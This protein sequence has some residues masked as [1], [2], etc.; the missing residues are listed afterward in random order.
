MTHKHITLKHEVKR[1]EQ[2]RA[3]HQR[4]LDQHTHSNRK[5]SVSGGA[6]ASRLRKDKRIRKGNKE[7]TKMV[8]PCHTFVPSA[9]SSSS[10]ISVLN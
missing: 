7:V 9:L 6:F 10:S 3:E 4:K 1:E 8:K 2:D 5:K